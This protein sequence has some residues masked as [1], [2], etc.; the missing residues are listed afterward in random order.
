MGNGIA[1]VSISSE[2]QKVLESWIHKLAR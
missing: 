1:F 2:S